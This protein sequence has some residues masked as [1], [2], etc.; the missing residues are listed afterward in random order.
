ML[1]LSSA[2][3]NR[4]IEEPSLCELDSGIG[5]SLSLDGLDNVDGAGE[6]LEA[7]VNL[8]LVL[9]NDV[10][11]LPDNLFLRLNRSRCCRCCSRNLALDSQMQL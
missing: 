5:K 11:I 2:T 7:L 1:L 10:G 3:Y 9:L 4:A 8:F 6:T